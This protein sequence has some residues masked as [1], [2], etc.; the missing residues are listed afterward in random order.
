MT[1]TSALASVLALALVAPSLA[2]AQGR[3]SSTAMGCDAARGTVAKAG[4]I[5]LGTG[6]A[7]YDRF[8]VAQSYCTRDEITEPAYAPTANNPQ[9]FIGYRCV[10]MPSENKT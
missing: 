6:G 7:T 9:C 5:V 8:V 1:R 10:V 4:A 3:L 2:N